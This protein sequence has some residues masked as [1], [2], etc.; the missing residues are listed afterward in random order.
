MTTENVLLN[1]EKII[2]ACH[3]LGVTD[4]QVWS[5]SKRVFDI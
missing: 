4:V 5:R 2:Q 3:E 1:K